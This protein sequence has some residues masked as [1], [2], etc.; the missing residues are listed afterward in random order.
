MTYEYSDID[1]LESMYNLARRYPGSVEGLAVALGRRMDKHVD[2]SVLRNKLR[3]N[4]YSHFLTAEEFSLIMELCQEA[5]VL[6]PFAPLQAMNLRHG[7]VAVDIPAGPTAT[8][9]IIRKVGVL[10]KEF[11]E[12]VAVVME[13]ASDGVIDAKECERIKKE[14]FDVMQAVVQ[15]TTAVEAAQVQQPGARDE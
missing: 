4:I 2:P 15:L 13:D 10:S 8:Q 6:R 5:N 9:D 12:L 14:A 11:A 3:P 7:M 1:P